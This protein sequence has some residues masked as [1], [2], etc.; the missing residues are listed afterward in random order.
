[1]IAV[2]D[3]YAV[4]APFY[5]LEIGDFDD[6]LDM[7]R[8]F[9]R[10]A[11]GSVLELG[12]GTGRVALALAAAG[13][14]VVGIDTSEAMLAIARERARERGLAADFRLGDMRA[15]DLGRRFE[16]IICPL[17][18][19][20]HLL[21]PE[22]RHAALA[23]VAR[24]LAPGGTFVADVPSWHSVPWEPAPA[25]VLYDWTAE[26]AGTGATVTKFNIL[27]PDPAEQI[28]LLTMIFDEHGDGAFR[29]TVVEVPLYTYT[30]AELDLLLRAAGLRSLAW[31]GSWELDPYDAS[32]RE[33]VV[34]AGL[35]EG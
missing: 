20:R 1:M 8:N 16:L 11:E 14:E 6:D 17:G 22:E 18:G 26:R 27:Q 24:H 13:H 3:P 33:L 21:S 4:L 31:Y 7:Y 34:V 5:D 2:P 15:L 32:S 23:A 9:A 19:L 30:R 10:R 25:A 29:R 28:Q 12:V 35:G